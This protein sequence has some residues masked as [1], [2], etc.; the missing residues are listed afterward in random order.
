M[1]DSEV[2]RLGDKLVWKP[3]GTAK[4]D[5]AAGL[6]TLSLL[7]L[8]EASHQHRYLKF[9]EQ[10]TDSFIESDGSIHGYNRDDYTLDNLNPGKTVLALYELTREPRYCKAAELLRKQLDSQPRTKDGGFWHKQ[11]YPNQMWLD[12]AYMASPFYAQC[13]VVFHEPESSFEDI[14]KQLQLFEDHTYDPASGL[15]Y[16]GWDE[17]KQQAWANKESGTS[18]NFWGRAIGW[19]GMALVDALD[20][21]PANYGGRCEAIGTLQKWA[22]GII[23][24]QD[25]ASGLWYQVMDQPGRKGNYLESTASSMFVYTFAKGIIQG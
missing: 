1:A 19:Y 25:S 3:Q 11:K 22:G 9:V 2:S 12:G 7:K 13:A 20:F 10:A 16:H 14:T 6:F 8:D 15:F 23:S 24:H 5:Y 18:S 17:S 4:W 21:M